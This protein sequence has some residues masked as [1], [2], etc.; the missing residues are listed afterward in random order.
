MYG[1]QQNRFSMIKLDN[2]SVVVVCGINEVNHML[3]S[4]K[5][6]KHSCNGIDF[7]EKIL[8]SPLT[9]N[10]KINDEINSLGVTHHIID[11][12]DY[13]GYNNFMIKNLYDYIKTDFC[14]TIQHDGFIL[15]PNLWSD[16]FLNYDY[17][18]APWSHDLIRSTDAIFPHAL[19]SGKYSLVGNGGF[20][21]RSRRLLEECKNSPGTCDKQKIQGWS[22]LTG[23]HGEHVK[24][25]MPE[26]NYICL[27]YYEY[28]I[29]K[30]IKYA[31]IEIGNMF[32]RE[33]NIPIS[34]VFGF[35]GDKNLSKNVLNG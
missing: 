19:E 26:D 34:E 1:L 24:I 8:I 2:V 29:D 30:G 25:I 31:P 33:G 9:D 5:A 32:S 10:K 11:T 4:L 3:D 21:F 17:I 14:V 12:L 28:F 20:S 15:N 7:S 18:G 16:E 22:L 6:L 23:E 35:H 13:V 27:N